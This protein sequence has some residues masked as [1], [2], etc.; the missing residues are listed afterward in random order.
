M[1][2]LLSCGSTSPYDVKDGGPDLAAA[3]VDHDIVATLATQA[4]G[5]LLGLLDRGPS[6]YTRSRN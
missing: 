1:Q 6:A 3:E 4:I 5:P 2:V